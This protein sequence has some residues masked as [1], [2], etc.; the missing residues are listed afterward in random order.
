MFLSVLYQLLKLWFLWSYCFI[1]LF[2]QVNCLD[3]VRDMH[4]KLFYHQKHKHE[5]DYCFIINSFVGLNYFTYLMSHLTFGLSYHFRIWNDSSN[6]KYLYIRRQVQTHLICVTSITCCFC[7]CSETYS[8]S[9]LYGNI[10]VHCWRL[11][12]GL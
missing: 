8:F 3:K 4:R 1:I 2:L 10:F 9:L 5:H 12:G 11:E 7:N 6:L